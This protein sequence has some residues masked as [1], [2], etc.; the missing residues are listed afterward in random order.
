M[1]LDPA[2]A[3]ISATHKH[4]ACGSRPVGACIGARTDVLASVVRVPIRTCSGHISLNKL[5]VLMPAPLCWHA[6]FTTRVWLA[7][8]GRPIN[9]PHANDEWSRLRFSSAHFLF[10]KTSNH[11]CRF[12]PPSFVKRCLGLELTQS[13]QCLIFFQST[14]C[15]G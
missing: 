15:A 14:C 5:M 3:R 4:V 2:L 13:G 6:C 11:F 7:E 8:D 12:Y 10:W 9:T 1:G